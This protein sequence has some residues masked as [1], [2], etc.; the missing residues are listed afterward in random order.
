MRIRFSNCEDFLAF[1]AWGCVDC[2]VQLSASLLNG[3]VERILME[4]PGRTDANACY[5]QGLCAFTVALSTRLHD[6]GFQ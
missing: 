4:L 6:F 3:V 5:G 1:K 2:L